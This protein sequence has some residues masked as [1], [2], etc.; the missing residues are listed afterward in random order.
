MNTLRN[1]VQLIGN[2]GRDP[3]V[4]S[5][6]NGKV[7]AKISVATNESYKNANGE[8]VTETQ[9]HQVI[10]WGKTAEYMGK[11]LKKGHEVIVKGKLNY[12][13]YQDKDGVTRYTTDIVVHEL[14]KISKD[15]QVPI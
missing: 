3:E 6:D 1:Q 13:N 2:L 5:F 9:W 12:R 8:T 11:Y 14:V 15:Q 4:K 10:A 7:L